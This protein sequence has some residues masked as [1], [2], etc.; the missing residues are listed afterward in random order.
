MKVFLLLLFIPT[1]AFSQSQSKITRIDSV[2]TY[3]HQ[4]QLFNGTVLIGEKGKALYK[5]AFGILARPEI[6]WKLHECFS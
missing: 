6:P 5:K 1:L 2:L 4:R 3:L